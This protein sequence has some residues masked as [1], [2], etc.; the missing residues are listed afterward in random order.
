MITIHCSRA[1]AH[2]ASPPELLTAGMSKAVTVQFVFSIVVLITS[3]LVSA[4]F[5]GLMASTNCLVRNCALAR[6]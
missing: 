6:A 2:L 1:C 5:D 3:G 4:K